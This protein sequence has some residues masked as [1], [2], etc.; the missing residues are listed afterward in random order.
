MPRKPKSYP[1]LDKLAHLLGAVPD[2]DIARQAGTSVSIVGRYRRKRGISAYEGYKFGAAEGE[3]ETVQPAPKTKAAKKST[4][5]T[6]K[7]AKAA[8]P[9]KASKMAVTKK[10]AKTSSRKRG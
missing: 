6:K 4:K 7:T 8:A 3:G 10:A 1:E 9:K 2:H 5:A